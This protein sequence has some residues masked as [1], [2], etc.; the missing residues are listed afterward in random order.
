MPTFSWSKLGL[1]RLDYEALKKLG[2]SGINSLRP[3]MKKNPLSEQDMSEW[4]QLFAPT[5]RKITR[6]TGTNLHPGPAARGLASALEQ[7][8]STPKDVHKILVLPIVT[9]SVTLSAPQNHTLNVYREDVR[10]LHDCACQRV[11][12]LGCNNLDGVLA[13]AS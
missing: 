8:R 7:S 9:Y 10:G 5:N 1:R 3:R 13:M 6:C 4:E 11:G 2:E 12:D